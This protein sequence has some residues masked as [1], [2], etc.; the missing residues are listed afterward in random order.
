MVSEF[1]NLIDHIVKEYNSDR[2][3]FISLCSVENIARVGQKVNK[4]WTKESLH[5]IHSKVLENQEVGLLDPSGLNSL[6]YRLHYT[7]KIINC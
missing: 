1:T 2:A 5:V 6:P 3:K 7:N 4:I